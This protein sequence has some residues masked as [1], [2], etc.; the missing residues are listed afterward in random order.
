V[1]E[2]EYGSCISGAFVTATR[3]ESWLELI[4]WL[5]GRYAA[6]H[7]DRPRKVWRAKAPNTD[8]SDHAKEEGLGGKVRSSHVIQSWELEDSRSRVAIKVAARDGMCVTVA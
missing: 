3:R 2:V 4:R 7:C 5:V 1:S 8:K 6:R